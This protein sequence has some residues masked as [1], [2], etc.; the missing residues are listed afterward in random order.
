MRVW[1]SPD[2]TKFN[3]GLRLIS[4]ALLVY[5]G[6][7]ALSASSA[8]VWSGAFGTPLTAV[9]H[10]LADL[11][12][13]LAMSLAAVS[14][15]LLVVSFTDLGKGCKTAPPRV[16][17]T[18]SVARTVVRLGYGFLAVTGVVF[19]IAFFGKGYSQ[20]ALP[21]LVLISAGAAIALLFAVTVP[22]IRL[23]SP[24]SA[25]VAWTSIAAGT[26]AVIA[27]A[28][29]ALR[30]G[31]PRY[32][33]TWVSFGG[34]PLVNWNLPFGSVVA[35]T[36]FLLGLAYTALAKSAADRTGGLVGVPGSS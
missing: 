10:R 4:V 20:T 3:R 36:S 11:A 24:R 23:G 22:L 28:W 35:V 14:L 34:Y 30:L 9:H 13:L 18:I 8:G 1:E 15:V 33:T 6:S 16:A 2:R 21:W 7:A 26:A 5:A 19:P 25:P 27:E 17:A 31:D 29:F 32:V 12:L